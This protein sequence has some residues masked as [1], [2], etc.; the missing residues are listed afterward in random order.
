MSRFGM[1]IDLHKCVGCGACA[2]A[3]KTENN[4]MNRSATQT[5]NWADYHITTQGQFPNTKYQLLPVLCNH[6]TDAP[7]VAIC[8]VTPVK[9]MFK[10]PDGLTLH[11]DSRC[12]GCR[13]CQNA[14]PYSFDRDITEIKDQYSVISYTEF[15]VHPFWRDKK[16]VIAGCTASGDEIAKKVGNIPPNANIYEHSDYQPVRKSNITEKCILCDHRRK[17]SMEPYCVASCPA[18][19]RTVGDFDDPN[20]EVSKLI[21]KYPIKQLKNNKGDFLSS[22]EPGTKPNVY[23]I[24]EYETQKV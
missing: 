20:S 17:D 8:P 24:R 10:S 16:E 19:A 3:C 13:L 18:R 21:A 11:N 12:I 6:C 5:F 2:I 15:T 23:Y 9:A 7:C 14:C 22:G 4:T 1:V